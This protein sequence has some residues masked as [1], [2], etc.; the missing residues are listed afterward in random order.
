VCL[1]SYFCPCYVAGKVAAQVGDS[2]LLCGLLAFFPIANCVARGMV[3]GKVRVQKGIDGGSV[4]DFLTVCCCA[5]CALAQ[6]AQEVDALS[7][8]QSISRE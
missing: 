6:E 2:C 8:A 3:R 7:M 4:G 5:C 1:C